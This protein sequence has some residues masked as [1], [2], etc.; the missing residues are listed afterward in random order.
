MALLTSQDGL[1]KIEPTRAT[2]CYLF[3]NGAGSAKEEIV[4]KR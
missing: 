4:R 3:M 1:A 2:F